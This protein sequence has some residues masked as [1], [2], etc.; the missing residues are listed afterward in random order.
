MEKIKIKES[1][2]GDW[3]EIIRKSWTW[4][5]LTDK[6]RIKFLDAL[7]YVKLYGTYEKRWQQLDYIYEFF[8]IGLSYEPIGW[9]EPDKDAPTF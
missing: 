4:D 7:Y 3:I 9:R 1:V 2:K 6:E 8:L 5:R